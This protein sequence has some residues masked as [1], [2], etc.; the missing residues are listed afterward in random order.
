MPSTANIAKPIERYSQMFEPT[1]NLPI[2]NGCMAPQVTLHR[3][4][5]E[6]DLSATK[7]KVAV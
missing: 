3:K 4:R 5:K 1:V 2:M 7:V 6:P